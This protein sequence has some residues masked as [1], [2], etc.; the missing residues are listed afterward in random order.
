[1]VDADRLFFAA[2]A[3]YRTRRFVMT[4]SDCTPLND[5]LIGWPAEWEEQGG[6]AD[7]DE[8][9]HIDEAVRLASAL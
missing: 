5:V 1:V 6:D 3:G 9:I 2:E 8:W 4:P 7:G